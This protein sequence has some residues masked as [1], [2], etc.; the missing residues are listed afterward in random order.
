MIPRAYIARSTPKLR[1]QRLSLSLSKLDSRHGHCRSLFLDQVDD[2]IIDRL[3]PGQPKSTPATSKPAP[4][5]DVKPAQGSTPT[6]FAPPPTT[7]DVPLSTTKDI[8][9]SDKPRS[10]TPPGH[11]EM[12]RTRISRL[13]IATYGPL[14]NRPL[15]H[16]S[17]STDAKPIESTLRDVSRCVGPRRPAYAHKR[18]HQKSL[19][20]AA[21]RRAWPVDQRQCDLFLAD[22]YD[23]YDALVDM[24]FSD[25]RIVVEEVMGAQYCYIVYVRAMTH[26]FNHSNPP[27]ISAHAVQFLPDGGYERVGCFK[28]DDAKKGKSG[29]QAQGLR[30]LCVTEH[31]TR[32]STNNLFHQAQQLICREALVKS[33]SAVVPTC[34]SKTGEYE[35][36]KSKGWKHR[37]LKKQPEYTRDR[38]GRLR[39]VRAGWTYIASSC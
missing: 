2:A 26:R 35:L 14:T 21:L 12:N 29:P 16:T 38:M 1:P 31:P 30:E 6:Q 19:W 13:G 27:I 37:D 25:I 34:R 23:T 7:T 36:I 17:F 20:R 8:K 18:A 22:T 24:G 15:D 32:L 3:H 4:A 11:E 28:P 10:I 5:S 39:G 9:P 33:I